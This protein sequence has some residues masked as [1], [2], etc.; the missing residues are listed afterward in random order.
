MD[1]FNLF[2]AYHLGITRNNG[3]KFQSVSEVARRF[4]VDVAVIKAKLHEFGIESDALRKLGFEAE[5]A[6]LDIKVAPEGISRRELAR[7]I[8]VEFEADIVP[9][10][11]AEPEP[12]PEPVE[13]AEAPEAAADEPEAEAD[14]AEVDE[15]ETPEAAADEADEVEADAEAA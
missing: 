14:E 6:Q 7:S 8:W 12:E 9:N 10:P 1:G 5:Y 15:A 2:C 13:E 3:Y 11:P 4:S